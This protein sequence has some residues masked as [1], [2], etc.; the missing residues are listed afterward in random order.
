MQGEIKLTIDNK[1]VAAKPGQTILQVARENDIEIPTLCYDPRLEPYGSCLLCVVEVTGMNRLVLSCTTAVAENM[2]V[3][4]NNE[5]IFKARQNALQLLLSNHFA[6]CRGPCYEMCPADVDVQGYLAYARSGLYKEALER[7]RETNPLPLVCGRVCVRYCEGACR[8]QEVDSPVAIN[9]IKRYVADLEHDN[10]DRPQISEPNGHA[11][12][13]VGGGPGGLT[14]AYFLAKRGYK[15][16]IFEAHEKLGGMLR[17]GI[18]DY[19]LPQNILDKEIDYIIGH[20][21][22]VETK[23]KLGID[24]TLDALRGRGYDAVF[25]ALGA[26]KAKSMGISHEDTP[27]VIGGIDFLGK[28]KREGPPDLKGN[29]VVVGGGNTAIDAAR[30]ALRCGAANVTILYRRTSDEMPAD[31]VEI[32]DALAEGVKIEYLVAPLDVIEEGGRVK[33]LRCQR[34][35]LGEPDASGRRRPV[36]IEND[37]F[38]V[39]CNNVIAAIGQDCDTDCLQG[40]ATGIVETTRSKTIVA[41]PATFATNIAGVFA[42]GD[43]VSGPAAAVDA[44]G[45]GRRAA[46]V[47]DCYIRTGKIEQQPQEF[48]SKK[49]NLGD[50]PASYFDLFDKTVRSSMQQTDPLTRVANFNEVDRG[51]AHDDVYRET[52]RC[53]SCGCSDVNTCELKKWAGQYN[54]DQQAFSGKANKGKVDDRHPYILLDPNKCVLCGKCARYCDQLLAASALGFINRGFGMVVRP[55]MEKP[56]QNT[57]CISCGNCI[58]ICPTGAISFNRPQE[59]PWPQHSIPYESVCNFCGVGCNLIFNKKNNVLWNITAKRQS[60]YVTGELCMAGRFGHRDILEANRLTIPKVRENGAQKSTNLEYAISRAVRGLKEVRDKYGSNAL[61][62]FISPRCTN[63]E[64]FLAQRLAREVFWTS[65]ITSMHALIRDGKDDELDDTLGLTASTLSQD[66]IENADVIVILNANVTEENPVLGFRIKRAARKGAT[67]IS[68][69]S[70]ELEINSFA[71][72]WLHTRRGTNTLL[73]SSLASRIIER[74]AFDESQIET[75]AKG[76][77]AFKRA[78]FIST[79]EAADATG[80]SQAYIEHLAEIISDPDKNVVYVYNGDCVREKSQGDLQALGN[81]VLLTGKIG[82]EGNGILLTREYS[83]SQGLIDLGTTLQACCQHPTASWERARGVRS[84]AELKEAMF[85]GMIKGFFI[86]GEDFAVNKDYA[87][88]LDQAEFVVAMDMFENETV[89]LANVAL[90]GSAYAEAEGSVTSL[91]RRVQAFSR[92]FDPPAGETGFAILA[93]LYG[94]ATTMDAPTLDRVRSDIASFNPYYK[95]IAH[96]GKDG[97]FFWNET[98]EG[99]RILYSTGFSTGTKKAIFNA[100][101]DTGTRLQRRTMSFSTIEKIYQDQKYHLLGV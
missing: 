8:R 85:G 44:I 73:L 32:E 81:L 97:F 80:V 86:I 17:Y 13:V 37:V 26:Q 59:R 83:N 47:I 14:A 49:T 89:A 1:Q 11:V 12:A 40:N 69:S 78:I 3:Q 99:G 58:E 60:P 10:L 92:V 23:V 38:D 90:P 20:G 4:T 41:D 35:E 5:K 16:K 27:G 94:E 76:F 64:I 91:D 84:L 24:F 21:I 100:T 88:L 82:K 95:K 50:I 43:V 34:M 79:A 98:E 45:A 96:I 36:P 63:E 30:T 31:K 74:K 53:L 19:R 57:T 25:L 6:D 33:S 70:T 7:I 39:V 62:F 56:L 55:S 67:V 61:A 65:N 68:I 29:V 77:D 66:Q 101:E 9:F 87:R 2:V 52:S 48:I 18:P 22:E 71:S 51:I 15:V 42:G 28:V 54:A 72:L 46:A 93:R 75:I